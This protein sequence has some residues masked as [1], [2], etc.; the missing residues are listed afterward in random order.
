[1]QKLIYSLVISPNLVSFDHLIL[2]TSQSKLHQ[3][4]HIPVIVTLF[5]ENFTDGLLGLGCVRRAPSGDLLARFNAQRCSW[6][7]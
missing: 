4:N 7:A 3:L 2:A 5:E 1:M 6:V